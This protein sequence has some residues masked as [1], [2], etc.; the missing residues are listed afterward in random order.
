MYIYGLTDPVTAQVRYVGR[1]SRP[2]VQRVIQHIQRSAA[3]SELPVHR[4]I[5]K[6]LSQGREPGWVVLEKCVEQTCAEREMFWVEH[7]AF[8]FKLL[9]CTS[10]GEK[11]PGFM[12]SP[13]TA[14]KI[15]DA[16][17]GR[18]ELYPPERMQKLWDARVTSHTAETKAK[19]SAACKGQKRTLETRLNISSA[20]KGKPKPLEQMEALRLI[21]IGRKQTPEHIAKK[22]AAVTG[23]KRSEETRTKMRAAALL[24]CSERRCNHNHE[25]VV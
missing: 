1:T 20:L 2:P 14:A 9:N 6:L 4:W 8:Q 11:Y 22:V 24:A 23:Q 13:E 3:G 17:R 5:A 18:S 25:G 19:I 12:L 7:F 15:G 10:G 21:N 16:L